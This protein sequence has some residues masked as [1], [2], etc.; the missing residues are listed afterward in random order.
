MAE[1]VVS[2]AEHA[3]TQPLSWARQNPWAFAFLVLVLVLV[4]LHFS[5]RM[6]AFIQGKASGGSKI[7]GSVGRFTGSLASVASTA[8]VATAAIL[9]VLW[10]ANGGHLSSLHDLFT[11]LLSGGLTIATMAFPTTDFCALKDE[12]G[13]YTSPLTAGSNSVERQFYLR[14][15]RETYK[16]FPLKVTDIEFAITASLTQGEDPAEGDTSSVLYWDELFNI[17]D[18][19]EIQSPRFGLMCERTSISG[20][21]WKHF[22]EYLGNAYS[23]S[24]DD[25]FATIAENFHQQGANDRTYVFTLYH[26]YPIMQRYLA[27]PDETALFVGFL[28][29]TLLKYRLAPANILQTGGALWGSALAT[30]NNVMVRAGYRF[31]TGA[32][33]GHPYG[34]MSVPPLAYC[35][36]V[37]IP[38][39]GQ[40]DMLFPQIHNQG[41]QN[42]DV[43]QGERL[44]AAIML[45]NNIGLPGPTNWEY[46][47][48]VPPTP[49]DTGL[50]E[51]GCEV[52]GVK[53]TQNPDMWLKNKLENLRRSLPLLTSGVEGTLPLPFLAL[54]PY[55][56]NWPYMLQGPSYQDTTPGGASIVPTVLNRALLG[57]PFVLPQVGTKI[58]K[59]MRVAG[60]VNV[61][62]R[63]SNPPAPGPENTGPQHCLYL[64]TLRDVDGAYA[65]QMLA[66]AGIAGTVTRAVNHDADAAVSSGRTHPGSY[67]G[68]P[69]GIK[70]H[71]RSGK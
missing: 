36:V 39:N 19:F 35:R 68:I 4:V 56:L 52:L 34:S 23:Y 47:P 31:I 48:G 1:G 28:Q 7:W 6:H 61:H 57:F 49:G 11:L 18:S 55:C 42:T 71:L 5:A 58:S 60:N 21:V 69:H 25:P 12:T 26:T 50:T 41:P 66:S 13:N 63:Q 38:A 27:K 70:E 45:S 53:Y 20:P 22:V 40:I 16:N 24:G 30:V 43:S 51:I 64:H 3:V 15:E 8:G 32:V 59:M 17:T 9:G 44:V 10:L 14:A 29:N 46:S 2:T 33:G 54:G 65:A 62:M 37:K 67:V